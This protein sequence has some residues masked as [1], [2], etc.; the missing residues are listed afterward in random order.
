M[1]RA[2]TRPAWLWKQLAEA[3][4]LQ[5][6]DGVGSS[7]GSADVLPVALGGAEVAAAAARLLAWSQ[8]ELVFKYLELHADDESVGPLARRWLVALL[9]LGSETLHEL[10]CHAE[11]NAAHLNWLAESGGIAAREAVAAWIAAD[12]HGCGIGDSDG[13]PVASSLP[14][15]CDAQTLFMMGEELRTCMRIDEQCVR[16]NAALLGYLA[17]GTCRLLV[18]TDVPSSDDAESDQPHRGRV[19]ARA[20]ARLLGRADNGA[21]VIFVDQPLYGHHVS[22]GDDPAADAAI[23]ELLDARLI[24]EARELGRQLRIPVVSWSECV[25]PACDAAAAEGGGAD[26]EPGGIFAG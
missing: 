26:R 16:E 22:T 3:L 25:A 8:P 20:M 19:A 13:V 24:D 2:H 6:T 23:R 10:R 1:S 12:R 17:H 14:G 21:P 11:P 9:G 7:G 15:V 5:V 18:V 4:S